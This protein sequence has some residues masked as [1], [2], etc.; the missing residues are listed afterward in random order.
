MVIA[1][2]IKVRLYRMVF[3]RGATPVASI[4]STSSRRLA[5]L[6]NRAS[7]KVIS[8]IHLLSTTPVATPPA[9]M[10]STNPKATIH[11]SM[12]ALSFSFTQYST[13]SAT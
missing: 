5:K 12:M 1:W 7:R 8:T 6:R 11:T 10:R 9:K 3:L 13:L 2:L 4:R